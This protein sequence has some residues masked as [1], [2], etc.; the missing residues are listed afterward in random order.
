MKYNN[1]PLKDIA[2]LEDAKNL[3]LSY[4]ESVNTFNKK[5][6]GRLFIKK[7]GGNSYLCKRVGSSEKSLGVAKDD[8]Y[9]VIEKFNLEKERLKEKIN[10]LEIR[11]KSQAVLV[12]NSSISKIPMVFANNIR[13]GNKLNDLVVIGTNCLFAYESKYG[14]TLQADS[15]VTQDL[16]YFLD[17]RK[18]LSNIFRSSSN[19]TKSLLE[20]FRQSDSSF[21]LKHGEYSFSIEND[22][23]FS[24]DFV[25]QSKRPVTLKNINIDLDRKDVRPAIINNIHWMFNSYEF[26]EEIIFDTRGMPLKIKVPPPLVF[27][28]Y[29]FF[30][31]E[32]RLGHPKS[33]KDKA[34]SESL[35]ELLRDKNEI[36]ISSLKGFP[37]KLI[38][39]IVD[40]IKDMEPINSYNKDDDEFSLSI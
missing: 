5:Y 13:A 1:L 39:N 16:D 24:I 37:K 2:L 40:K 8:S 38:D 32:E 33:I 29:K 4:I 22:S 28:A 7:V 31:A 19:V 3:A 25:T 17:S 12:K 23:G 30:L 36:D 6:K 14:V 20:T 21:V 26:E 34:Q 9:K 27:A 18:P 35:F 15:M 11:I 10:M